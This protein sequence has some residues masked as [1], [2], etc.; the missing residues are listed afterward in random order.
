METR[1]QT[2]SA[3]LL[4]RKQIMRGYRTN[5]RGD[6]LFRFDDSEGVRQIEDGFYQNT[7]LVAVQD[8]AAALRQVKNIIFKL[9]N[10]NYYDNTITTGSTR[11]QNTR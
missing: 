11:I 10:S 9:R 1:D 4:A 6:I 8:F 3:L 2:L 5:E 7:E